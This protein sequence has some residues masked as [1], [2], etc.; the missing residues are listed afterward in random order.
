MSELGSEYNDLES[1]A[2]GRNSSNA[3]VVGYGAD[4]CVVTDIPDDLGDL[5]DVAPSHLRKVITL[6]RSLPGPND[7]PGGIDHLRSCI[8]ALPRLSGFSREVSIQLFRAIARLLSAPRLKGPNATS[9]ESLQQ[10]FVRMFGVRETINVM[11]IRLSDAEV[12]AQ[13]CEVLA[14]AVQGAPLVAEFMLDDRP[15]NTRLMLRAIE[16]HKAN[17]AVAASGCTLISH[18][19]SLTPRPGDPAPVRVKS[20][21]ECQSFLSQVGGSIDLLVSILG[22][23]VNKMKEVANNAEQQ[24]ASAQAVNNSIALAKP[25]KDPNIN[26]SAQ[27]SKA[28]QNMEVRNAWAKLGEVELGAARI[29][30]A[31][32][33]SLVLLSF[34]NAETARVLAGELWCWSMEQAARLKEEREAAM[35]PPSKGRGAKQKSKALVAPVSEP[36]EFAVEKPLE[37]P[38]GEER[39]TLTSLDALSKTVA[40]LEEVL[41]GR[42][43]RDRPGIAEK[44]C[45]LLGILL[46]RGIRLLQQIEDR[47]NEHRAKLRLKL[48]PG[49]V[50]TENRKSDAPFA[51]LVP[52]LSAL[53]YAMR[54]HKENPAVL[55]EAVTTLRKL[56]SLALHSAPAGVQQCGEWIGLAWQDLLARAE[57]CREL[58]CAIDVLR[59]ALESSDVGDA[60]IKAIPMITSADQL[61]GGVHM[62][63]RMRDHVVASSQFAAELEGDALASRWR[64]GEPQRRERKKDRASS[65]RGKL[66]KSKSML[67]SKGFSR[68]GMSTPG[69]SSVSPSPLSSKASPLSTKTGFNAQSSRRDS[70]AVPDAFDATLNKL[71]ETM[72]T[73]DGGRSKQKTKSKVRASMFKDDKAK[74]PVQE[75]KEKSE[76]TRA[77]GW[78]LHDADDFDRVWG[79]PL[80]ETLQKSLSMPAI[81]HHQ[82]L[83]ERARTESN[84]ALLDV[85]MDPF[86]VEYVSSQ[87]G[88]LKTKIVLESKDK[89]HRVASDLR[90]KQ[91]LTESVALNEVGPAISKH[92]KKKGCLL[93]EYGIQVVFKRGARPSLDRNMSS[94]LPVA[95]Q[96]SPS[97][98]REGPRSR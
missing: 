78:G 45:R 18:L 76:W 20:H 30:D 29:Q 85:P 57:T 9:R 64:S 55:A 62:T 89:M 4:D 68:D 14:A 36:A 33:Q 12:V 3:S 74:D 5:S 10:A 52:I 47:K 49:P 25:N 50:P 19:C 53:M 93:P 54:M 94:A 82:N 59:R 48:E 70:T 11:L 15:D 75:T 83:L 6:L 81:T 40:L 84:P 8:Q 43:A 67:S 98:S 58:P 96:S 2:S 71:N 65:R 1:R 32:L 60:R 35:R 95:S 24:Y 66:N 41:K 22:M 63:P 31:A 17:P 61:T 80:H 72:S 51:P 39:C 87:P 26:A 34:G 21:R 97:L 79:D 37:L 38:T 13:A 92:M 28:K 88:V 69:A 56:K 90:L 27:V 42:A 44:A 16:R 77:L 86:H 7:D 23:S 91:L 46:D 73:L